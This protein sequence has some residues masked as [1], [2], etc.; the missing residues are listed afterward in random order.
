MANAVGWAVGVLWLATVSYLL[1][2]L[3][4]GGGI[5]LG[6]MCFLAWVPVTWPTDRA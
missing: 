6:L 5:W 3:A 2:L 4:Y 1:G